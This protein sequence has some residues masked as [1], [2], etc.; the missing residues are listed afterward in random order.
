MMYSDGRDDNANDFWR[1]F[2]NNIGWVIKYV[3]IN[4]SFTD[5]GLLESKYGYIISKISNN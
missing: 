4:Y 5:Y 1:D 3:G 2:Y